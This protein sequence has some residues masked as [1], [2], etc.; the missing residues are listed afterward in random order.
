[1]QEPRE[2]AIGKLPDL[3]LYIEALGSRIRGQVLERVR[4][5]NPFVLRTAVPPIGDA[6]GRRVLDLRRIGKH[7]VIAL[8]GECF[9]VLHLMIAGRLRWLERK[10]KP[11]ARIT[12]AIFEFDSGT[13][14]LTEAGTKRRASL[15]FVADPAVLASFDTSGLEIDEADLPAFAAR[16]K[17]ENLM[18]PCGRLK[19][20]QPQHPP[21]VS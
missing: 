3:T 1:M 12:L 18:A 6:E 2:R 5:A 19:G 11:P 8:E 4:I 20:L 15:H 16:L 7:I 10:E 17:R 21:A 14:A 13:L 9:L